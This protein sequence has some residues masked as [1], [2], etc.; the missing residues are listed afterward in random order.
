VS[1]Y[2]RL[3]DLRSRDFIALYLTGFGTAR[4]KDSIFGAFTPHWSGAIIAL[5]VIIGAIYA[6]GWIYDRW[7]SAH[8]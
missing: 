1:D 5:V 2:P 6:I 7:E 3:S 4:I 8:D